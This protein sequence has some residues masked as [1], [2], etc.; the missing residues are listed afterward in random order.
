MDEEAIDSRRRTERSDV[1]LL[2]L[3]QYL[4][5]GEFLV[6]EHKDCRTS[7]PLAVELAPYCLTPSCVSHGEVDAVFGKVVPINSCGEMSHRIKEVMGN[8]L[9]FAACSAGEI[10]EHGVVVV[11]G[12]SRAHKLRSVVPLLVPVV[13]TLRL[14]RAYADENLK[15]RALSP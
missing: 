9:R 6:V 12:H 14:L 1:I 11:V 7:E 2:Y 5:G 8:H 15:R 3:T 13:K 10:H 4:V